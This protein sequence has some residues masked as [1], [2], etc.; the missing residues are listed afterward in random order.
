MDVRTVDPNKATEF[1]AWFETFRAASTAGRDPAVPFP[2]FEEASRLHAQSGEDERVEAVGA[3]VD[4]VCAGAAEFRASLREKP[5]PAGFLLAVLPE[6]R[7]GGVGTALLE[8]VRADARAGGWPGLITTVYVPPSGEAGTPGPRFA[9]R[10]GFTLRH[11]DIRRILEVPL[12]PGR[13]AELEAYA[14]MRSVGYQLVS[15][16]GACP[17]EYVEQF[18]ELQGLMATE[19]P[20]GPLPRRVV[21]WDAARQRENERRRADRGRTT[22]VTVAVAPDGGLAG[23]THLFSTASPQVQQSGTLVVKGH[24]GHRLGLAMKLANQRE[25]LAAEPRVR[26][27]ETLNAEQNAPMVAVNAQLGFVV[28]ERVERWQGELTD[29]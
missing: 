14:A 28:V 11:T 25:V 8:R 16:V 4:G 22:Y 5:D 7:S 13:L 26:Q 9:R 1:R 12:P 17:E 27:I 10:Y 19:A 18:A 23:F 20:P 3:F 24:R 6:Y 29:E 21:G 15:W 2:A